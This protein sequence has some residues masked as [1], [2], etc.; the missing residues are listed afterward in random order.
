MVKTGLAVYPAFGL[1]SC[2]ALALIRYR[3]RHQALRPHRPPPESPVACL[4]YPSPGSADVPGAAVL[5]RVPALP[6]PIV[7]DPN[8]EDSRAVGQCEKHR[9]SPR[10]VG[11]QP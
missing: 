3:P 9:S 7:L 2:M 5:E 1:I 6:D 10:P 8:L 11:D 4:F